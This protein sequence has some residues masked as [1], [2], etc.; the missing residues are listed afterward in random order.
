[1]NIPNGPLEYM[2]SMPGVGRLGNVFTTEGGTGRVRVLIWSGVAKL[3]FPHAPLAYPDGTV[4]RWNSLRPFIGY[5]PEAL[6]VAF[7][8]FYPPE[9]AQIEAR[10]ASPDRSHN[11]T[12]DALAF[13]G[14]LGLA[15]YL[16]LFTAVFYYAL[17]WLGMI[18]SSRRRNV[19]LALVLVG[20]AVTAAFF[21]AW[22]GLEFFG[23]GLP[24]GMLLGLIV[25]LTLY[26]LAKPSQPR[27]ANGAEGTGRASGLETWRAV[28]MISILAA[29]VAHFTEI[30]F[31]IA[32]VSTRTHF[33]VLTGL[34]MV[35]GFIGPELS[36]EP[37]AATPN[38]AAASKL[39]RGGRT[40]PVRIASEPESGPSREEWAPVLIGGTLIAAVMVT[41]GYDFINNALRAQDAFRILVQAMTV[42]PVPAP[43]RPSYAILGLFL[44]TWLLGGGLV[45][46]E[47]PQP[48][49]NLQ[50]R[51]GTT[52]AGL[53]LA[54]LLGATAWL[55]MAS[56]LVTI[57]N[58]QPTDLPELMRSAA[59][60]AGTVTII[61]ILLGLVLAAMAAALSLDSAPVA[62]RAAARTR[63]RAST[64]PVAM[65]TY[66]TLP[67][68]AVALSILLN[69]NVIQA[70][71]IYKTGLQ[72]DDSGQPQAAI[73]LYERALSLSPGED[74]YYLFLGR[75]YLNATGGQTNPVDRD[76]LLERAEAQLKAARL[77]NPLNTDHTANLARLNRRWAELVTETPIRA[78]HAQAA[79]SYYAEATRLSPHNAG[80][81]N[82][83]AALALQVNGDPV[84]AQ[85]HL[86]ASF[87]L[88]KSFDQTWQLQGDVYLYI[89]QRSTEPAAQQAAFV[90]A[91]DTYQHGLQM[92][93][94]R[95][96]AAGNVR[97]NLAA[98]YTGSGQPQQALEQYQLLLQEGGAG[99]EEWRLRL[100]IS[101]LYAQLG[102]MASARTEAE[103]ALAAA[104]EADKPTVQAWL[105]RLP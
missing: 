102:N 95:G 82:E 81:W 101:Q 57:V 75:S 26:S 18:T 99:I 25:F 62:G 74:Y 48:G 16:A 8:P 12:F 84:T 5:G 42:L 39:R 22:Q 21:V 44:L 97:V 89:A 29:V 58:I 87:D 77:L 60:I 55:V 17:K 23:V 86:D 59:Q 73:P 4:D 32:I 28:A 2:R 40:T 10:N 20:G 69:L 70:D 105:D 92:A 72:F 61:Y 53:G 31:G 88:D 27:D 56:H 46:L 37:Q 63:G 45:M 34:L 76:A 49:G 71:V 7:N 79:D 38:D 54:L 11:E 36:A 100:A 33:W 93:I 104:P 30:H 78:R 64:S 65:I 67:P 91:I 6:Y 15:V 66:W 50:K 51:L 1:L 41:L 94:A 9:L 47:E 35:L 68:L 83:W 80:I 85:K 13:T 3:V 19:F 96:A 90:Q 14:L 52:F 24:F 103:Q 43:G 98:A